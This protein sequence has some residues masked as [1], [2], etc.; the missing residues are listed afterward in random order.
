MATWDTHREMLA[1][2]SLGSRYRRA[3]TRSRRSREGAFDMPAS[4]LHLVRVLR[5]TVNGLGD[6]SGESL[7]WMS[8]QHYDRASPTGAAQGDRQPAVGR[9][10][11]RAG[12]VG[13]GSVGRA[14]CKSLV[15]VRG[16][17]IR[18]KSDRPDG[19]MRFTFTL[20]A[21]RCAWGVARCAGRLVGHGPALGVAWVRAGGRT[22]G[23]RPAYDGRHRGG[24]LADPANGGL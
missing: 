11:A 22:R 21:A 23:Y 10:A 2:P 16:G 8:C 20:P 17:S 12:V 4:L 5:H 1:A 6:L 15:E 19:G 24:R 14:T 3:Y 7:R 13:S 9:G 18:A